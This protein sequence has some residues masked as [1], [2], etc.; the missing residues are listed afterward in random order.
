MDKQS[1]INIAQGLYADQALNKKVNTTTSSNTNVLALLLQGAKQLSDDFLFAIG[2]KMA[3]L[4]SNQFDLTD[5][6]TLVQS[7]QALGYTVQV[8]PN[9]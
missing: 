8:E 6:S 9:S 1:H 3:S 7:A 2:I 5:V 4:N